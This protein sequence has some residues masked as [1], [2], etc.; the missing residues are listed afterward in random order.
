MHARARIDAMARS[1]RP[2]RRISKQANVCADER[3]VI[4]TL[5][6]LLPGD[7]TEGAAAERL[8][9]LSASIVE[10]LAEDGPE[11]RAFAGAI[12][13]L[14]RRS[15]TAELTRAPVPGPSVSWQRGHDFAELAAPSPDS[16][17]LAHGDREAGLHGLGWALGIA[18]LQHAG[19]PTT[20]ARLAGDGAGLDVEGEPT[21]SLPEASFQV[22]GASP[23]VVVSRPA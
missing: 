13:A 9:D 15:T 5:Q 23:P 17:L 19:Q 7:A 18:G 3:D 14:A 4:E 10:R 21:G 22:M 1:R 12:A 6:Y 2:W 11:I 16:Q 20:G 8:A